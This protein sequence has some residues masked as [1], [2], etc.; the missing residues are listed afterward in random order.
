MAFAG[1][2][3]LAGCSTAPDTGADAPRAAVDAYVQ[4]LNARDA[5]A[6]SR[7]APPGNDATDDI[8]RRID[9]NGGRDI[10]LT[11]ADISS[12][13]TPDVAAARLTGT[14]S[15]GDY[16]ERITLA[17]TDGRWYVVL[18][19]ARQNPSKQPAGTEP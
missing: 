11:N 13:T 7:L 1:L 15:A 9:T 3:L 8:R 14:S 6:L 18:G 17:R 12:E 2:G 19:E 16:S 10:R 4:A 5:Q